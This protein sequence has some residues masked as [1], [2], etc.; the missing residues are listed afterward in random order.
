MHAVPF[1]WRLSGALMLACA[2]AACGGSDGGGG[3]AGASAAGLS[4]AAKPDA[5]T[6][7]ATADASTGGKPDVRYAP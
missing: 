7:P 3:F 4:G 5:G 6:A 1:S 2:L